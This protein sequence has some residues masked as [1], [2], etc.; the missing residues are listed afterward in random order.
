MVKKDRNVK[1]RTPKKKK[2]KK[3]DGAKQKEKGKIDSK[4]RKA[5][6]RRRILYVA[7]I[8]KILRSPCF[9]ILK[10]KANIVTS[11]LCETDSILLTDF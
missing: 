10:L 7:I 2:G 1:K 11:N 5:Q 3:K 6:R 4:V 8:N 9:I